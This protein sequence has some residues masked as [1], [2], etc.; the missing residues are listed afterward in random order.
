MIK[1][2]I[3][4]IQE[5]NRIISNIID[6]ILTRNNFLICGHR[7]PDEDC[8]SSMVA[9]A[10]LLNKFDKFPV[11]YLHGPVSDNLQYLIHICRFNSIKIV[12]G[13]KKIQN[14]IDVI[15]VC[16]TPKASMIDIPKSM[17]PLFN[18]KEITKI[19]FD[20]HIGGDG[21]Y[22]GDAGHCLVT[23]ASSSSEL[24]GYLAL[25]L[26]TRKKILMRYLISDPFSRN[27][28]LAILTGIIGDTNK[29]Q[30]L[31]S[32]RE[33]KFYEIFSRMYNDILMKTTVRET[34]FTNMDQVF[35]EL[36]H[37][38][39]KEEEC[40][41]YMMKRKQHSNSIGYIVLSRDESKRLFH[42]FDEETIISV[43]KAAAN[44]LAEKS[45]KLS[46]ICYYDMPADTG[47]IQFRMRRSHIFKDYDL[48]HVLKLFSVTNGGGHEGAIGF[49]FDRKS[50]PHP[51][52]FAGDM[53]ARIEKELQDLAGA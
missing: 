51:V 20:H 24:V 30:F 46:L 31:K 26:R 10:I 32:R 17:M 13:T 12:T 27:F 21:E 23:E 44:E 5:K 25:K 2:S 16:D 34:N 50:M 40:F 42:E 45:G 7:N 6:A 47:L 41:T 49:R 19:E 29:G 39:K 18:K 36:Q 22:I 1:H 35:S 9:I 8:I 52:R 14:N 28:V 48:R 38:S 15:I 53:I 37:L 11:I 33:Q 4:T 43:T 3:R